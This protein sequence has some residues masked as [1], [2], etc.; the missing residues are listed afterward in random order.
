[1]DFT[2]TQKATIQNQFDCFCKR[3]IKYRA[4]DKYD[5]EKHRR[6]HEISIEALSLKEIGKLYILDKP[7]YSNTTFKVLEHHVDVENPIVAKALNELSKRKRDIIL[8]HY[9]VGMTDGQIGDCLGI[10]RRTVQYQ[11][12][13]ALKELRKILGDDFNDLCEE[14]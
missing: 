1:M 13:S 5:A 14:I 2:A 8:L 6:K 11:R 10:V 4:R 7:T 12:T 9:F 3:V